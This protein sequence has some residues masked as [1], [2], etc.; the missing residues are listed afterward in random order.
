MEPIPGDVGKEVDYTWT[1]PWTCVLSFCIVHDCFFPFTQMYST[2]LSFGDVNIVTN[3]I[4]L[5]REAGVRR[6]T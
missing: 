5:S 3:T 2:V 4:E 6:A 1:T